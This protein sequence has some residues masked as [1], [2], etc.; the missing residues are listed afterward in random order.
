MVTYEHTIYS[1]MVEPSKRSI[2]LEMQRS[3]VVSNFK[4]FL[5]WEHTYKFEVMSSALNIDYTPLTLSSGACRELAAISMN[6]FP[7]FGEVSVTESE[8]YE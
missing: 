3:G 4:F 6:G 2:C 8:Y 1:F 5:K 7:E